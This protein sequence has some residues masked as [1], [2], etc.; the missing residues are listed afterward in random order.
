MIDL[1]RAIEIASK[2]IPNYPVSRVLD[3]VDCFAV[4]FNTGDFPVPGVPMVL[5]NKST[6]AVAFLTI[7]PVENLDKVEQA[8]VVWEA[9]EKSPT[10]ASD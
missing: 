8:K 7:P 3:M 4:E 9:D 5:V 2:E 10:S 1:Q 6:Q